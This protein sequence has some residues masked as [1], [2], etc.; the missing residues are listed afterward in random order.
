MLGNISKILWIFS[1]EAEETSQLGS[2]GT[3]NLSTEIRQIEQIICQIEWIIRQIEPL[4]G[5][6]GGL[7]FLC[8]KTL[9]VSI[10][11]LFIT[12]KVQMSLIYL[13]YD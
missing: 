7:M 12:F 9:N 10:C 8:Q 3:K 1:S 6:F 11:G 13:L 2:L 4:D 5:G